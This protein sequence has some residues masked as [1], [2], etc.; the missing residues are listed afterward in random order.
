MYRPAGSQVDRGKADKIFINTSG[1]G[2]VPDGV[3]IHPGQARPGD[4]ILV[5][6][7]IAVHGIAIMSVREGLEF[8]TEICSDTTSLAGLV[9]TMLAASQDIHVLRREGALQAR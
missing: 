1:V 2:I 5:S 3:N 9:Q 7:P 6:G 4:K 8:E